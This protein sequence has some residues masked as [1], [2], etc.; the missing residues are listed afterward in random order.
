MKLVSSLSLRAKLVHAKVECYVVI[1]P[2]CEL[3]LLHPNFHGSDVELFGGDLEQA[4]SDLSYHSD[5]VK[6]FIFSHEEG[7]IPDSVKG[8]KTV[9]MG[10]NDVAT[11]TSV[12]YGICDVTN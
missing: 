4:L 10:H 9:S 8:I 11:D 1:P 7:T 2:D 3:P 6:T 5:K 12:G